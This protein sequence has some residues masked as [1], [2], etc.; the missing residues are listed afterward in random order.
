MRLAAFSPRFSPGLAALVA[1]ALLASAGGCGGDEGTPPAPGAGGDFYGVNGVILRAWS[2]QGLDEQVDRHLAEVSDSGA[3]FVRA[4]LGWQLLEPA[5]PAGGAHAYDFTDADRWVTALTRHGLRWAVLGIG[6]PTPSWAVDRR[7]PELCAGRRPPRSAGDFAAAM[8]AVARRYGSRG[9]FWD[10]H[11]ALPR[12]PILAYE[13]WNA[14][15]NGGDWCPYP[16]PEGYAGLYAATLSAVHRADR[17]ARVVVGGLGAFSSQDPG[18]V[19]APRMEPGEFLTRMLARRPDLRKRVDAVGI[20]V[21]AADADAVIAGVRQ[22]RAIVDGAGLDGVPLDWSEVGWATRGS[23]GLPPV[24]ETERAELIGEVTS[25]AAE[26][27]CA[28]VT[29]AP[30][31]WVTPEQN[32]SDQEDWFGFADPETAEPYP[33]A[34]A[35]RE[36]VVAADPPSASGAARGESCAKDAGR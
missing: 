18:S 25:A 23:G 20:H 24:P 10:E 29:F 7:L 6:V 14:P 16:N 21:Y 5:A 22:F 36:A 33:S 32:P 3:G 13:V 8:A 31:A 1:V 30:H 35:Y 17:E 4:T 34:M 11:S 2:S 26:I 9:T 19:G 15:N 12:K 28:V 27:G